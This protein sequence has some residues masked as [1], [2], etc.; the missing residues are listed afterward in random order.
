MSSEAGTFHVKAYALGIMHLAQQRGSVFTAQEPNTGQSSLEM[1]S[2]IT[3]D[4]KFY[5]QLGVTAAQQ[6]STRHADTVLTDT[7]HERR[8]LTLKRYGLAD[9][10]D[11]IDQVRSLN[12]PTSAFSTSFAWAVGR[13]IDDEVIA[14]F[15]ATESTGVDGSGTAP[16]DSNNQI[17]VGTTG[18]T[19]DKLREAREIL[20]GHNELEDGDANRWYIATTARQRRDLLASTEVTSADFN[21]VRALVNGQV[22]QFMGFTFIKTQRLLTDGSGDQRVPAWS[23]SA[24]KLGFGE[25]IRG[26]VKERA[27]KNDNIQVFFRA[28][29]GATRMRETGVVE[30][31]CDIS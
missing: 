6:I 19:I 17:A 5:D 24:M 22:D 30:I 12:D 8:M 13:S 23:K 1:D 27:D 4:R 16:F 25:N 7:P 2:G 11:E 26:S 18:L 9:L 29:F 15:F 14:H 28:D 10:V 20:E 3:G 31:L 21:S